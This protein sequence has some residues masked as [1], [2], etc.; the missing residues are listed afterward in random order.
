MTYLT[1][2]PTRVEVWAER[3]IDLLCQL[4]H[5]ALNW[6]TQP[7]RPIWWK[8]EDERYYDPLR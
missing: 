8:F 3:C 4:L 6:H 5:S 7:T 2:A 1:N